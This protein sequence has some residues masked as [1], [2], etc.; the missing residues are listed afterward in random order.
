MKNLYPLTFLLALLLPPSVTQAN[1]N[2]LLSQC[3]SALKLGQNDPNIDIAGAGFCMGF[4]IG[5]KDTLRL[6]YE[7]SPD[8]IIKTCIPREVT[9]FQAIRV[10]T[11]FL[12]NHPEK[13]HED[14][15]ILSVTALRE[16]FPCE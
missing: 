4:V 3:S 12:E 11:K 8:S 9:G 14:E 16:A 6:A 2:E 5:I 1:G 15:Y 13:L 7:A 10:V